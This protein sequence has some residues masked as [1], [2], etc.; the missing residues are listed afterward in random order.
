M[1]VETT[2]GVMVSYSWTKAGAPRSHT[3]MKIGSPSGSERP[4]P[5]HVNGPYPT[6]RLDDPAVIVGIGPR[7]FGDAVSVL[8][9]AWELSA[10]T[11]ST[12]R[13]RSGAATAVLTSARPTE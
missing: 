5:Y 9:S 6:R 12:S 4:G 13:L 2:G 8:L 10:R 11:I 7:P 3:T 1:L